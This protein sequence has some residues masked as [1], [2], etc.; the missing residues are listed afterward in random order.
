MIL[1]T[2]THTLTNTYTIEGTHYCE[3][4]TEEYT[5]MRSLSKTIQCKRRDAVNNSKQTTVSN[6]HTLKC[7]YIKHTYIPPKHTHSYMLK[8]V[9]CNNQ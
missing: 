4:L 8:Q 2:E 3:I 5:Y 1:S 9:T 6:S 7:S